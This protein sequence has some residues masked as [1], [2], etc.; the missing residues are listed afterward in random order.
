MDK[1]ELNNTLHV[2]LMIIHFYELSS[3]NTLICCCIKTVNA[4]IQ[5]Y[6]FILFGN[7]CFMTMGFDTTINIARADL[8]R[9]NV[10]RNILN[11]LPLLYPKRTQCSC[12][13]SLKIILPE[14]T[15]KNEW[16]E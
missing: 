9:R 3:K 4:T 1:L 16:Y 7:K 5:F 11:I 13:I 12:T 10:R 14:L 15:S 2:Y 6:F 8:P